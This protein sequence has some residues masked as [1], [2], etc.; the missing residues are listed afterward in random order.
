MQNHAPDACMA[1]FGKMAGFL[2]FFRVLPD[3][4]F[5][6]FIHVILI[7]C[8]GVFFTIISPRIR[9]RPESGSR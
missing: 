5:S 7:L 2:V 4:E 6:A 8:R 9:I 3:G 1:I